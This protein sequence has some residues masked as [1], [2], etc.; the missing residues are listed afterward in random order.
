MSAIISIEII[1]T[2]GVTYEYAAHDNTSSLSAA[3]AS[4]KVGHLW[5]SAN[6]ITLKSLL[7]GAIM[8]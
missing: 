8:R 2:F 4:E 3:Q 6:K 1:I 7:H 5:Y